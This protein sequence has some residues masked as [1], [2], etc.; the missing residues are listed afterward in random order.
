MNKDDEQ[1]SIEEILLEYACGKGTRG[2][3]AEQSAQGSNVVVLP[4]I[5]APTRQGWEAQ[6]KAMA[7]RGDDQLLDGEW[8]SGSQWDKDEWEW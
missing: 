8:V 7:G 4:R 5:S 6:F 1:N 2:Q 3:Y